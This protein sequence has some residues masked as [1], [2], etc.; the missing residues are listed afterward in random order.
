M[1]AVSAT[2]ARAKLAALIAKANASHDPVLIT[3]KKGNAVLVSEDDWRAIAE[4]MHLLSIPGL[5]E[6]IKKGMKTPVTECS[7]EPGW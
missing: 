5:V 1:N 2:E 7:E 3:S 6:D 4:T